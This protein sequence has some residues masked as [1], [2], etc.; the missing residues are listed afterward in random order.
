[1]HAPNKKG[2]IAVK[3]LACSLALSMLAATA[4]ALPPLKTDFP[5]LATYRITGQKNYTDSQYQAD[6]SRFDL[7]IWN[8][9]SLNSMDGV[10]SNVRALHPGSLDFQYS[11]FLE[12]HDTFNAHSAYREEVNTNN[13]WLRDSGTTGAR[14]LSPYGKKTGQPWYV[15]NHTIFPAPNASGQRWPDAFAVVLKSKSYDLTA[16]LDGVFI[17]LFG[18]KPTVNGDWNLD[19]NIDA[20]T[21]PTTI[22][23]FRD[24]HRAV[25]DAIKNIQPAGKAILANILSWGTS[26]ESIPQLDGQLDGGLI[27]N[28]IGSTG[29]P[30]NSSWKLMMQRYRRTLPRINTNQLVIFQAQGSATDYKTFRYA[31]ASALMDNA[32]FDWKCGTSNTAICWFDEYDA[33]D[34]DTNTSWLG[35]PIDPPQTVPFQ[36]G[37]FLRRFTNGVAIVNPKGNG[38]RTITIGPG[39]RHILGTQDAITNNGESVASTVTL[40]DRDGLLL[41]AEP[42]PPP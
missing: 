6:I 27:E 1:M 32:Y 4:A 28:L 20:K 14:I 40:A 31:F 12:L 13:W 33:G 9:T 34:L 36:D 21:D 16:H 30:E 23:W 15:V 19:N 25:L 2:G 17:D 24:G 18:Q 39:Y 29:S 7:R 8:F 22:G 5:R 11:M 37:V 38:V 26:T 42:P 41:V 10:L 3:R 35:T